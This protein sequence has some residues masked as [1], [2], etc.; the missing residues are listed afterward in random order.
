VFPRDY[1]FAEVKRLAVRLPAH[2]VSFRRRHHIPD[3]CSKIICGLFI[4]GRIGLIRSAWLPTS[5]PPLAVA[6]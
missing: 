3:N 2:V 4:P 5:I 6:G 1:G